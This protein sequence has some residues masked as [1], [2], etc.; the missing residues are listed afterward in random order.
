[1][2]NGSTTHVY[3]VSSATAVGDVAT[4]IGTVDTVPSSGPIAV[5]I[6]MSLSALTQANSSGGITAVKNLVAPQMLQA[7]LANGL[8]ALAPAAVTQLPT[9]T[10]TQ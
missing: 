10:F 4:I 1:M 9:G 3:V 7:A 5:T 2:A 6:T 8:P